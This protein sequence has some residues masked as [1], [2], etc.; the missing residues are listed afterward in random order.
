MTPEGTSGLTQHDS[1]RNELSAP[2]VSAVLASG[3]RGVYYHKGVKAVGPPPGAG[4][5]AG[6]GG[7]LVYPRGGPP[8]G[9]GSIPAVGRA[10]CVAGRRAELTGWGARESRDDSRRLRRGP[11]HWGLLVWREICVVSQS[12]VPAHAAGAGAS[13]SAQTRK[14]LRG[15]RRA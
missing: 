15:A 14:T 3:H 1:G 9:V 7:T 13:E 8:C 10:W 6:A 4:C 11:G 12:C 2:L 5:R